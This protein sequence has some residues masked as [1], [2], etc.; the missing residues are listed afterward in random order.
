MNNL[1][2]ILSTAVL[3]L[4][5]AFG[6]S[7][8]SVDVTSDGHKY[9]N[10]INNFTSVAT[11]PWRAFTADG[12]ISQGNGENVESAYFDVYGE[13][14]NITNWTKYE[15]SADY[16]GIGDTGGFFSSMS[17]FDGF[18]LKTKGTTL[19]AFFNPAVSGVYWNTIFGG[20]NPQ[21]KPHALS[22]M[23]FFNT[24]SEVPVP[25]A[26]WLF[27]PA[28]LGLMGFRRRNNKA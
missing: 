21:G 19:V 5:V 3:G 2:K 20:L 17:S 11:G 12:T 26:L 24:V 10:T 9:V 1:T 6:A 18:L 25:A 22:H 28:L 16:S 8:A 4:T 23:A 27:A 13:T 14:I 7:A 15:D